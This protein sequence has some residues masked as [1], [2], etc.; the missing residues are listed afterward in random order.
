MHRDW[1]QTRVWLHCIMPGQRA[2]Q[3]NNMIVFISQN[4]NVLKKSEKKKNLDIAILNLTGLS[5]KCRSMHIGWHAIMHQWSGFLE[6]KMN[7][8]CSLFCS[9]QTPSMN[10]V[11]SYTATIENNEKYFFKM[12]RS[13]CNTE[14]FS[15]A[16]YTLLIRQIL[17]GLSIL[18]MKPVIQI[19]YMYLS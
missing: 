4:V 1:F 3:Y 8:F 2:N 7:I 17:Y 5:R 16:K 11:F 19:C 6:Q 13:T 18:P 10:L 15:Y 9:L 12:S 14:E